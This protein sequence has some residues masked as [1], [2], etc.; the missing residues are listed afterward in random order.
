MRKSLRRRR[1]RALRERTA[2]A[3]ASPDFSNVKY[4]QLVANLPGQPISPMEKRAF[5]INSAIWE[6]SPHVFT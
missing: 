2:A 6:Q 5:F 4:G 3:R 1:L